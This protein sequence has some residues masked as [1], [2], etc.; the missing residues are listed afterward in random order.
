MSGQRRTGLWIAGVLGL[1]VAVTAGLIGWGGRRGAS[2]PPV[3]FH[4]QTPLPALTGAL[5]EG[6]ARA[7]DALIRR[8]TAKADAPPGG[9]GE[10]EAAEWLDT[11]AGLRTGFPKFGGYGR[12]SALMVTTKVLDRFAGEPA[13]ECWLKALA[14]AHDL[15][16]S[17]LADPDLN[18]RVAAL[19]E[20]SRLWG[21]MPGRSMIA[22]EDDYLADWKGGLIAPV[23]RRLSDREPKARVAA[24]ACLGTL[25]LDKAAAPAIPYLEDP[26]GD[27]R[28]QVLISFARRPDLLSTDAI[29]MRLYDQ[30]PGIPQLAETVLKTRGLTTEQIDLARLISHPKPELRASIIP[31]LRNRAADDID[32]AVWLLQLSRDREESVRL[33]AVVALAGRVAPEVR[34]RLAEIAASDPS[35]D[36]R[37]AAAK[38]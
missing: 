15:L 9:L 28:Q 6:D 13:P 21:W 38:L 27:V 26:S 25:P 3:A 23:V 36:V 14:P 32:P 35:P 11:L 4:E 24:V 12:A 29:I 2:R 34:D 1:A 19:V 17:G 18:V 16:A 7:L 31:M 20:V 37:Q 8:M 30:D 22:V 33:A 10:A 5:R